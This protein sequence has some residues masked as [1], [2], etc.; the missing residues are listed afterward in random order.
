[1][2]TGDSVPVVETTG[3]SYSNEFEDGADVAAPPETG[4]S[5][6][7]AFD[8]DG[9]ANITDNAAAPPDTGRSYSN[10]FDDDAEEA[11]PVETTRTYSNEFESGEA[12]NPTSAPP[13]AETGRTYSNEFDT[14]GEGGGIPINEEQ[15]A[16]PGEEYT[17]AEEDSY[18]EE[19]FEKHSEGEA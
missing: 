15:V 8:D 13:L 7:N 19:D 10:A 16:A 9:D 17:V 5:Y 18:F 6:S 11:P 14:S 4:R 2:G 3:Q 1:M 12:V